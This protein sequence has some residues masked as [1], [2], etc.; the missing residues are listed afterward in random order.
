MTDS[1]TSAHWEHDDG[2]NRVGPARFCQ[3]HVSMMLL[4]QGKVR[5]HSRSMREQAWVKARGPRMSVTRLRMRI[6]CRELNRRARKSK[7]YRHLLSNRL[8]LL[9]L[10]HACTNQCV[11]KHLWLWL[12]L[13]LWAIGCSCGCGHG[14]GHGCESVL[15]PASCSAA[16]KSQACCMNGMLVSICTACP[17]HV[18]FLTHAVDLLFGDLSESQLQYM[19]D[20]DAVF[21]MKFPRQVLFL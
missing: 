15:Q 17:K 5:V 10:W 19:C 1:G 20:H 9:L 11:L 13:W 18:L 8:I 6:N 14:C 4:W 3:L 12:W 16:D 7:R 21:H 2:P